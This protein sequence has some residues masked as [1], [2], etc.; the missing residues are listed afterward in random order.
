MI[1]VTTSL[2]RFWV[3]RRNRP[4]EP[5]HAYEMIRTSRATRDIRQFARYL[6]REAGNAIAR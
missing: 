3:S 5:R 6:Q 2:M 1:W 4:A